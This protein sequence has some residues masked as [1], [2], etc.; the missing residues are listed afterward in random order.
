MQQALYNLDVG[1]LQYRRLLTDPCNAPM[2][3]PAYGGVHTGIYRRCRRIYTI[4]ASEVETIFVWQPG[5]NCIW[6]GGH[7]SANAGSSIT[8]NAQAAFGGSWF[9]SLTEA[10]AL[11]ACIKVRYTGAESTRSGVVG[12]TTGGYYYDVGSTTGTAIEAQ[13]QCPVNARLGETL[14]EVKFVP[15]AGDEMFSAQTVANGGAVV[16]ARDKA[17]ILVSLKG[18]PAGSVQLELTAVLEFDAGG[19]TGSYGA[20][21]TIAPASGNTLSQVLRTLGPV[22]SWAF[23]NVIVPTIRSA[24]TGV[25]RTIANTA[26]FASTGMRML[27]L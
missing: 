3:G 11:A 4:P 18:V 23:S 19:D 10:R 2:V 12:L 20:L 13:T 16:T 21:T 5:T 1:A 24:A 7:S 6:Q 15:G 14:H 22:S 26:N 27:A 17:C 25:T 8:L 9:T